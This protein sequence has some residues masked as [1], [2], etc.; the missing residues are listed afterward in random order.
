MPTRVVGSLSGEG[1]VFESGAKIAEVSYSV[2]L[3]QEILI[4]PSTREEVA[5]LRGG[6]G[7]FSLTDGTIPLG[8]DLFLELEDGNQLKIIVGRGGLFSGHYDFF[9]NG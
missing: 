9:V 6:S 1:T 3:T 4:V 2:T 7:R 8:H 5:G